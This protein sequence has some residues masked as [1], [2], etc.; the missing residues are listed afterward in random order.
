MTKKEKGG[1]STGIHLLLTDW[2][3]VFHYSKKICHRFIIGFNI[4]LHSIAFKHH[5]PHCFFDFRN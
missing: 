4:L 5:L 1:Y 2:R 3:S